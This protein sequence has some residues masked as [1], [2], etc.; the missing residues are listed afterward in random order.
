MI[1]RPA[2]SDLFYP[3]SRDKLNETVDKL[4]AGAKAEERRA[5]AFVAPH[6]GYQ[7]SGATAAYTYK[8]LQSMAELNTIDTF[9]IVGPNHTGYGDELSVSAAD[10]LMP[11]GTVRNDTEFSTELSK[12]SKSIS[13][14]ESAHAQE[15]S[16]E[17]Q[18]PFLQKIVNNPVCVFIC[19]GDQSYKNCELLSDAIRK[20]SARLARSVTVIASSDFNHYESTSIAN[21]KDIPAINALDKIDAEQFHKLIEKNDDSACGY[22]PI[23]AAALY[24]RK[25]GAKTGK[26][27]KYSNSGDV[28]GDYNSVVAY[29]SIVFS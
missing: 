23:T 24:A 4:L 17:V 3:A 12:I 9:V 7:Y 25:N 28:T 10:W 29:A 11:F 16:V 15:H 14:D 26:L 1:R 2:V 22:G 21:R 18:L 13:L 27:L 8:A 20:A 19:M 6:A 5:K